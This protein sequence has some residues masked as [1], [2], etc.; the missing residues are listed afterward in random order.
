MDSIM[1]FKIFKDHQD[2]DHIVDNV[3]T[4]TLTRNFWHKEKCNK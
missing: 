2:T 3:I 4:H 1:N